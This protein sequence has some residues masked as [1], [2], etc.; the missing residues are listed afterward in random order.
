[1]VTDA[2]IPARSESE[3]IGQVISA[4]RKTPGIGNIFVIDDLSSDATATAASNSGG[5]VRRG[6]GH[7]K[8]AAMLAGLELTRTE[9][10]LFC[11]GDIIGLTSGKV[12]RLI[13]Q[14]TGMTIGQRED[15]LYGFIPSLSGERCL[16]AATARRA[17]VTTS[18]YGAELAINAQAGYEGLPI[19]TIRLNT[20]NPERGSHFLVP[21]VAKYSPGLLLYCVSWLLTFIIEAHSFSMKMGRSDSR[22]E[23]E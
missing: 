5:I 9:R 8:A 18:G 2:V 15:T 16:P 3:T 13:G 11:D 12:S 6:P 10:V 21:A 23:P 20:H 7:G 17:L 19:R 4:I 22:S 1:M 14:Q